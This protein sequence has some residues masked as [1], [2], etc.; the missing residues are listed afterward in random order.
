MLAPLLR[1]Y[2]STHTGT[3]HAAKE[4]D[5]DDHHPDRRHLRSTTG[6][7]ST[8]HQDTVRRH[9]LEPQPHTTNQRVEGQA[10]EGGGRPL[11]PHHGPP[12][13]DPHL[14]PATL[15]PAQHMEDTARHTTETLPGT[16]ELLDEAARGRPG[17]DQDVD[18]GTR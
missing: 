5:A 18:R 17:D 1:S 12:Q 6:T 10:E 2:T 11:E 16:Q 7:A 13:P 4:P 15:G 8:C 14:E 9:H 3:S